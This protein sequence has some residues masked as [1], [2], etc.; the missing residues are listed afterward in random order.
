MQRSLVASL[1][2]LGSVSAAYVWPSTQD[3]IDDLLYLQSGYIR[4]G[5][6]SDQVS[7]CGFGAGSPG[8]QKSAEWVRTAFH[9]AATHDAA[10]GTGGVDGSIQYEL[11]RPENLGAALNHTLADISSSVNVHSSAADLLSLALV[12]AVARCGDL[13]VPLRLGRKD[14]TEAGI[15]GV[16]E[17]HTDLETTRNRFQIAGFNEAD[18]I[19]LVA[20]GH[21][22]GGV[23]SVDHPEI[24]TGTVD[25]AN[26][27][28]FDNT[29]DKF[30]T[31]VVTEYLDNSSRNPLLRNT[32]DTLNS[33]KRVF[34]ADGNVTMNK[35]ADATY[36]KAQC[37]SVFTRMLDLVPSDVT[38]S[39]PLQPADIR[40]YIT[41]YQLSSN[42]S[43]ELAGRIRIRTSPDSG[44]V[45]T[46]LKV[47]LL[48]TDRNG[49]SIQ[50]ITTTAATAKGGDSFG[51]LK[52]RF[53]WFEFSKVL[54]ATTG[55][56]GFNIKLTVP[57][58]GLSTTY[59]NAGAAGGFALNPD[60][61]FQQPQSCVSFDSATNK[62]T[63]TLTT[64][65]SKKALASG[66]TPQVRLVQRIDQPRNFIPKLEQQV[67][68]MT[69]AGKET[70]EYV[71]YRAT[72]TVGRNG[73]QT[74]FDVEVGESKLLFQ[75]TTAL[76]GTTCGA[77]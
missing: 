7:S 65:I 35:L 9:D 73:L 12:I 40:P 41:K 16:P 67:I 27:A 46:D 72:G 76:V 33:D 36:Y 18:M 32:N 68:Q 14:A 6:L 11:E 56:S 69:P 63:L 38:L 26:V 29:T 45:A 34:A 74:T 66:A 13:E 17:A 3:P 28:R 50:E 43:V 2:L 4:F 51:Y 62:G 61:T 42:G 48:P 22:L 24:V 8:I 64:A 54:P 21:T 77:L 39:E 71:Y 58:S 25:P 5:S 55:L 1:A 47:S 57:S 70:A 15:K 59:D 75:E 44:R 49:Q 37:E 31:K 60:I 23:H 53:N 19:T 10:A 52:E 30:D 20:C